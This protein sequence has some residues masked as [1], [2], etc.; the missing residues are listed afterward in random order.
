MLLS[1]FDQDASATLL[2]EYYHY[3]YSSAVSVLIERVVLFFFEVLFSLINRTS[4][5]SQSHKS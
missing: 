3:P 4:A 2:H 5:L 1:A